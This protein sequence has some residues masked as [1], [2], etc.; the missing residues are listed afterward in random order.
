MST[1]FFL[2]GIIPLLIFVI[3]DTFFGVKKA[4]IMAILAGVGEVFYSIYYFG[5]VDQFSIIT[6]STIVVFGTCSFFFNRGIFI[7]IQPVLLSFFFGGSLIYSYLM[8]TP[9]LLEFAKK[10]SHLLPDSNQQLIVIPQ[11]QHLLSLSTLTMGIG[12]FLHGVT[13]LIAALYL[14]NWWWI[15]VRG[16]GFYLFAFGSILASRFFM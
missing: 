9:L 6:I 12:I 15:A 16:I 1:N 8:D 4:A 11:F 3:I 13:T 7:K 5:E 2:M 10:Y 14:S